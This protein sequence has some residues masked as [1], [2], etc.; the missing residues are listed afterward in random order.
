MIGA[1]VRLVVCP[2]QALRPFSIFPFLYTLVSFI[3]HQCLDSVARRAVQCDGL[4][5]GR[6]HR[7]GAHWTLGGNA[8]LKN[9]MDG[10]PETVEVVVY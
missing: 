7:L 9:F 2:L 6:A 8:N 5:A 1:P 4:A 3:L 10:L